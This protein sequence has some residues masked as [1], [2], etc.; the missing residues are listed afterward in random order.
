MSTNIE[1]A[2]HVWNPV[3]G[4]SKVSQGCKNCYAEK[5]HKRL[6]GMG[7]AKYSEPFSK[8]TCHHDVVSEPLK[9]G[10]KPRRVFVNS[11][12]DLFHEDVP[13]EFIKSVFQ[14]MGICQGHTFMILTKRPERMYEF[15]NWVHPVHGENSP[16][17]PLPNVWL[18]TSV[19]D[20]NAANERIPNLLRCPAAV[21]FISCE[22]LLGPVNL[23]RIEVG[24]HLFNALKGVKIDTTENKT[25]LPRVQ[26]NK[27]DWVI[28][29][30]ES[31]TKAR[32]MHPIWAHLLKRQCGHYNTAFFFK[33]WGEF[34]P[35]A[36]PFKDALHWQQKGASWLQPDWR[37]DK[38]MCIDM[39]G[40]HCTHGAKFNEALYPVYPMWKVG[41]HRSGCV[42]EGKEYKEFPEGRVK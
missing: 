8:V 9:W 18:G 10:K 1:W 5:M 12:S 31:G 20:Q 6:T 34:M 22:P 30:G 40:M 32:P 42:L 33:Q 19:E 38:D 16:G 28:V 11:M 23:E 27:I 21:R 2:T 41:K 37:R 29:G 25:G 14:V 24:N 36:L 15:F 4:C 13:F 39:N 26:I 35:N 17:W 3:T 7:Q